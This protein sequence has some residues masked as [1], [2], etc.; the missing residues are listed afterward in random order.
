[1]NGIIGLYQ[2]YPLVLVEVQ[3]MSRFYFVS[4]VAITT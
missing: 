2:C 1:M 4:V 3:R